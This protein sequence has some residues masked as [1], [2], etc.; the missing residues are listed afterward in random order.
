MA[1]HPRR[2]HSS[3]SPP[4][5]PQILQISM[6]FI[7]FIPMFHFIWRIRLCDSANGLTCRILASCRSTSTKQLWSDWFTS[8]LVVVSAEWKIWSCP[9]PG[10]LSRLDI[11][12]TPNGKSRHVVRKRSGHFHGDLIS[13]PVDANTIAELYSRGCV[14]QLLAS[15]VK[16]VSSSRNVTVTWHLH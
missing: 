11:A 5:K 8:H 16:P 1:P 4:W 9:Y 14:L 6:N 7:K 12:V 13:A 15:H 10:F 3:W 2:R